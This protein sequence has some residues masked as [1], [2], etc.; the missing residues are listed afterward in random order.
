VVLAEKKKGSRSRDRWPFVTAL[1]MASREGGG[2]GVLKIDTVRMKSK[3]R[4][5]F[6]E[7]EGA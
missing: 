4:G 7:D 5:S 6:G 2:G 1:R 3:L